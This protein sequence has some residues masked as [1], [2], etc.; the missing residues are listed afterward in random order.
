MSSVKNT[1]RPGKT[2]SQ[3]LDKGY[4]MTFGLMLVLVSLAQADPATCNL[5]LDIYLTEVEDHGSKEA[6]LCLATQENAGAFLLEQASASNASERT[7]RA[8]TVHLLF[9]L[10]RELTGA[11]I[12]ALSAADRRLL[13]DGIYARRGRKSPSD[14]HDAIFSQFDWYQPSA[15]FSNRQLKEIDRNNMAIIDNPPEPEPVESAASAIEEV[16]ATPANT[17]RCGCTVN[18][19]RSTGLWV[20][21]LAMLG[22]IRR[23]KD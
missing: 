7:T 18:T 8:L 3:S 2:P 16:A 11:E 4:Q 13:R 23:Q 22:L 14:E 19:Q 1:S 17:Q 5:S 10:D 20:G 9:Q 6:Y 12:R 15:M 21:L